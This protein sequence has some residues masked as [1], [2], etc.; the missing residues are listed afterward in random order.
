MSKTTFGNIGDKLKKIDHSLSPKL[1]QA[2]DIKNLY[3][4]SSENFPKK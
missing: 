3:K 4:D 1:D 2:F